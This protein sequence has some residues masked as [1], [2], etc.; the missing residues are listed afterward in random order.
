MVNTIVQGSTPLSA[1]TTGTTGAIAATIGSTSF[2]GRSAYLTGLSYQS[3]G[4]TAATNVTITASYAPITGAA[5]TLG[6]W[7]YP[8]STG[9]TTLQVPLELNLIPPMQANQSMTGATN[10]TTTT[11]VGS[12]T[13]SATA[14]GAGTTLEAINAWGYAL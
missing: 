5:V 7:S 14:P 4:A 3:T 13:V 8:V 2:T 1:T 9:V 12:I 11:A 6:T 10:S